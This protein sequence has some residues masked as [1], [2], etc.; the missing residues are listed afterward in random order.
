MLKGYRLFRIYQID[1]HPF[2][3]TLATS[4]AFEAE[5]CAYVQK[6]R[7]TTSVIDAE[8]RPQAQE[9]QQ[10]MSMAWISILFAL[11]ACGAQFCNEA[12]SVR[13]EQS[14]LYGKHERSDV[15]WALSLTSTRSQLCVRIIADSKFHD[16]TDCFVCASNVVDKSCSPERHASTGGLDAYRIHCS[17]GRESWHS[18]SKRR[19]FATAKFMV[20]VLKRKSV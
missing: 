10:G 1:I 6:R 13:Q 4:H 17:N 18:Q 8:Q 3:P 11:L 12:Y 20:S 15:A 7:H 16:A 19:P 14:S 9:L 5:L 2:V